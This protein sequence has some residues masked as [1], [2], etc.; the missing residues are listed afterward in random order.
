MLDAILIVSFIYCFLVL[1]SILLRFYV[2]TWG[3]ENYKK[4]KEACE[5][6]YND[7]N[8]NLWSS[9]NQFK[10]FERT[11]AQDQN[12]QSET[13]KREVENFKTSLLNRSVSLEN[14]Q[15]YFK[16]SQNWNSVDFPLEAAP[17]F[18]QEM[19]QASPFK[20]IPNIIN[21]LLRE[22]K[23]AFL[24]R[25]IPDVSYF[26]AV[27]RLKKVYEELKK[28]SKQLE[29]A[30]KFYTS[31]CE[32]PKEK[33]VEAQILKKQLENVSN[34][35]K[36]DRHYPSRAS[37]LI[38]KIKQFDENLTQAEN[39]LINPKNTAQVVKADNFIC[40]VREKFDEIAYEITTTNYF[41][42]NQQRKIKSIIN[43]TEEFKER[44]FHDPRANLL[45]INKILDQL[46]GWEDELRKLDG[47][48]G[49]KENYKNVNNVSNKIQD[50]LHIIRRDW[51][52][53]QNKLLN[54]TNYAIQQATGWQS[55]LDKAIGEC[56]TKYPEF[57]FDLAGI[58]LEEGNK[59]LQSSKSL[60]NSYKIDDI[61][62]ATQKAQKAINTYNEVSNLLKG[63]C[64]QIDLF[65]K[66]K[67]NFID[68][69]GQ[70]VAN[71]KIIRDSISQMDSQS[72]SDVIDEASRGLSSIRAYV[73]H[74]EEGA[75]K[76]S[77]M[78]IH[79]L[80]H[81]F[82]KISYIINEI[83]PNK[84]YQLIDDLVPNQLRPLGQ[85]SYLWFE[86]ELKYV[87]KN[88]WSV[89]Q[90]L[91]SI[92]GRW[93]C[94]RV[95]IYNEAVETLARFDDLYRRYG[96]FDDRINQ[97]KDTI[98]RLNNIPEKKGRFAGMHSDLKEVEMIESYYKAIN[99]IKNFEQDLREGG[100]YVNV[101]GSYNNIGPIANRGITVTNQHIK[102]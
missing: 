100:I 29:N 57:D 13:Y 66:H 96:Y 12:F 95:E 19:K 80:N 84:I 18:L 101:H 39:L 26:V 58:K 62:D 2:V 69:G 76:F 42:E 17:P 65:R 78:N 11:L 20:Y 87:E 74:I 72:T 3:I 54:E 92:G 97:I 71:L 77:E 88:W 82:T 59:L 60:V 41:W 16:K 81:E 94:E 28:A 91:R 14:A 53:R 99:Y 4:E 27:K 64:G 37:S 32:K 83:I 47:L 49:S 61:D 85:S 10:K 93:L 52:P 45:Y 5:T 67:A 50:Q 36:P 79:R 34:N 40:P 70:I 15:Q 21:Y 86:L 30:K 75:Q 6:Y 98:A 22:V 89:N 1:C 35:F 24:F 68:Y 90:D 8:P 73:T 25:Y 43:N 23:Q 55:H 48:P 63:Y 7:K 33:L 31:I 56:K 44:I 9:Y 102:R 38:D 46:T 51:G